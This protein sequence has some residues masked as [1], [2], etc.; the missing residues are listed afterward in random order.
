MKPD[1][2]W[3]WFSQPELKT[4]TQIK[5]S[6]TGLGIEFPVPF[7]CKTKTRIMF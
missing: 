5:I 1:Q 2:N 6:R 4:T 7:I 3:P